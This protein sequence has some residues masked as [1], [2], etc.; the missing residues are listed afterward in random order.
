[1]LSPSDGIPT[2]KLAHFLKP[3]IRSSKGVVFELPSDCLD[4]LPPTFEPKK[5][6]LKVAYHGWRFPQTDGRKWVEKMAALHECTWEKAG[7]QEAILNSVYKIK[8]NDDLVL[9]LAEK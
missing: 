3:T 6:P 1:M 5:W 9:G 8:R 4:H 7:L 2:K